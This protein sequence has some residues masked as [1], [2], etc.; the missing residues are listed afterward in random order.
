MYLREKIPLSV[1]QEYVSEYQVKSG[2]EGKKFLYTSVRETMKI[3]M[4][5]IERVCNE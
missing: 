4:K 2:R 1:I 3:E 5:L